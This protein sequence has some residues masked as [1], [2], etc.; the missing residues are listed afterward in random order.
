MAPVDMDS[1][2]AKKRKKAHSPTTKHDTEGYGLSREE[3]NERRGALVVQ[4]CRVPQR[5]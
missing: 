3:A 5:Q 1:G 4:H 2:L